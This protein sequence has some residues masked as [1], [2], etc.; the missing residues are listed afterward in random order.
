LRSL[1][2]GETFISGKIAHLRTRSLLSVLLA[3]LVIVPSPGA[4]T[5]HARSR[6]KC[7]DLPAT[8]VGTKGNDVLQGTKK[9]D[10][11][12]G[13]AGNDILYGIGANDRICGG[14]GH[15]RIYG[16]RGN[17]RLSGN[18]GNDSLF[19]EAGTDQL[20]GGVGNDGCLQGEG[21][22]KKKSCTVVVA[23]AGD[24]ACEP[25][26][27][28]TPT[29]CHHGAVSDLLVS[30][31]Y[32]AVM[33][34]GDN[35]YED[36]ALAK[37]QASYHP[38]WGRVNDMVHP[39]VGNHEYLT[40]G[41]SGYFAYFGAAAGVPGQG[42]YSYDLDRWHIIVVNSNCTDAGGCHPGSPQYN[43]LAADLAAH[44][45][46]CTLAYWHI[47]LFSSGG[48]ASINTRHIWQLLYDNNAD[49]VLTGHDHIYERFGP[50]T[51]TGAPD[52]A[53][54]IRSFV[55]GTGGS[56]HTLLPSIAAN[57]EVRDNTTFGA[58]KLTLKN[59]S[60]DWQFVPEPGSGTFTDAGSGACH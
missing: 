51:P 27:Q 50:Q 22:G 7:Q 3:F 19:G 8:I 1:I 59:T 29:L 13:L 2:C 18:K 14:P 60:Y 33:P 52:P 53:R 10:V 35:Q 47:P 48:R 9:R 44:P 36:G 17:D 41:A 37:F 55:V 43:W 54:G 39:S 42:Y 31:G 45:F 4:P 12:A 15:D 30:G 21:R 56:N 32:V 34:L 57:S 16:G 23:A 20:L 49:L 28:I 46:A 5:A 24:I 25:G 6:P 11:I 40:P 38:T 58:L 26:A